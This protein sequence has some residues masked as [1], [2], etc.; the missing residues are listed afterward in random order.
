VSAI[1][2]TLSLDMRAQLISDAGPGLSPTSK[3]REAVK[4]EALKHLRAVAGLNDA[5]GFYDR[6]ELD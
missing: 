4:I 3:I 5:P 1:A 2:Q 6:Q